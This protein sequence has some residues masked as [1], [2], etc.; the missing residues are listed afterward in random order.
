M[1][2]VQIHYFG[3][4]LTLLL[5]RQK[6]HHANAEDSIVSENTSDGGNSV[7]LRNGT[8]QSPALKKGPHPVVIFYSTTMGSGPDSY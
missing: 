1:L 4:F 6:S 2:L 3:Q 5:L 7:K 8:P